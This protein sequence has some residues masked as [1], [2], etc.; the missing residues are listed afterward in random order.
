[1]PSRLG[2]SER[3]AGR[4]AGAQNHDVGCVRSGL[5]KDAEKRFKVLK[6]VGGGLKAKCLEF[7]IE[8]LL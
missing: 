2:G 4:G 5:G 6:M 1:M 3:S 8:S 7:V